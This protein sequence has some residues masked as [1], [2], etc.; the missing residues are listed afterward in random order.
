MNTDR[1]HDIL[2]HYDVIAYCASEQSP[3][4]GIHFLSTVVLLMYGRTVLSTVVL[5]IYGRT[6]LVHCGIAHICAYPLLSTV[7]SLRRRLWSSY[8]SS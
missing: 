6:L 8:G 7:V 4:M 2:P 5:P 3:Y 1:K